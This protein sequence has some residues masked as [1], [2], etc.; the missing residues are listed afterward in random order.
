VAAASL[1]LHPAV[2]ALLGGESA[3][4]LGL[5][6]GEDFELLLCGPEAALRSLDRA[7]V[8]VTLIGRVVDAHPGRVVVWSADGVEYEPPSRGWDQLKQGRPT[9]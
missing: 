6:G 3:L 7:D 1:P 9:A 2:V 8:P 4:D 5:G